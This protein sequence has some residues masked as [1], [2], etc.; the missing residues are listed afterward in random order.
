M[1]VGL[2]L[3]AATTADASEQT[4]CRDL[5][6]D[7]RVT[8]IYADLRATAGSEQSHCYVK[9]LV[10]GAIT[11]QV[12]LPFP[13]AWNGR[14]VHRGDGGADGDLD[15]TDDW[16]SRGYAVVNSNT[17]H[18]V[19]GAGDA[20]GFQDGRAERDFV[21]RAV[22][23]ATRAAKSVVTAY[24]ERPQEFAYHVGCST[25][26]RQGLVAAQLFPYDFDGIVAG[27]PG[28]RQ[29]ERFAHRL[30]LE[31][32]LFADD[33]KANLAFDADKDGKAE[34]L[35]KVELLADLVVSHC[36]AEDGIKDGI[37]EPLLCD[38]DPKAHLPACPGGVDEADCFTASQIAAVEH[39]YDGSHN[40]S[41]DLVY[42]GAPVGSERAWP[43]V[44][45]PHVANDFVP[46]ALRS[47][48]P[49]IAYNFYRDDPGVLPPNLADTK[50]QLDKSAALPEWGWW[51]F[52]IDDVGSKKM[53][54]L[55]EIV[56]GTNA[57]L[58]RFLLRQ[59]GKL[60]LYHGW[61]DAVIPPEPTLEYH[62]DVIGAVFDEDE[63]TA[64]EHMRLFMAPGMA[65]CRGGVGP[66]RAD[67]LGALDRWVSSGN[68]PDSI[69]ARHMTN[70]AVDYERPLCPHPQRAVYRGPAEGINDSENWRAENFECH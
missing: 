48:A 60:L 11:F 20:Y 3:S 19:G 42:P 26:G 41:G 15:F 33:F 63:A 65:H 25:G 49:V 44:F 17:G 52:D 27:A 4:R 6:L 67:Y 37:L 62:T 7:N 55:S 69:L 50:Y 28:H 13:E 36:D 9:G 10:S 70:G 47:A 29:F 38:F 2:A 40:S 53:S 43:Q 39:I 16:V 59:G 23:L 14:L 1:V 5:I 31:Q 8:L 57:N 66:D 32:R 21:Y 45:I 46:Y 24:Y 34:S 35:S 58:D 61:A 51:E 64:A 12:Q 56:R 30:H 68:A 18:D 54:D 22:H